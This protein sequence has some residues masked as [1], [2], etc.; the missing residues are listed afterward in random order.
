M[1]VFS[2]ISFYE[3]T[4]LPTAGGGEVS[5]V[6]PSAGVPRGNQ[7]RDMGRTRQNISSACGKCCSRRAGHALTSSWRRGT[8]GFG[9]DQPFERLRSPDDERLE[10]ANLRHRPQPLMS[11]GEH[12]TAQDEINREKRI[13]LTIKWY[14]TRARTG[15][16][17][18]RLS[19]YP[20][21]IC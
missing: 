18:A 5:C 3:S 21:A 11:H 2:L 1:P 17:P 12:C 15:R 10:L 9:S 6:L 8:A 13:P 4:A 16:Q 7:D 20:Q 19:C 14:V